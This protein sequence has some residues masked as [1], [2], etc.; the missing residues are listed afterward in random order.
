MLGLA[1]T[2]ASRTIRL[3]NMLQNFIMSNRSELVE[4]CKVKAQGRLSGPSVSEGVDHGVPLVLTLI[5]TALSLDSGS[6]GETVD[7]PTSAPSV[8]EVRLSAATHGTELLRR[9]YS[10]DHVAH[11]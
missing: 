7:P 9:G 11:E 10:I 2:G 3:A 4:R 5:I 1:R 8:S 6:N